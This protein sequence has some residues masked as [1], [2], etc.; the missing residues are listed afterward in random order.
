MG[1]FPGSSHMS[2]YR[3]SCRQEAARGSSSS[4]LMS[5]YR[6]QRS[7]SFGS[8]DYQEPLG[9]IITSTFSSGFQAA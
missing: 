8:S 1:L 4:Q 7:P 2:Y 5:Y 3:D 9:M 6:P